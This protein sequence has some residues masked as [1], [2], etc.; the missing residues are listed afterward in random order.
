MKMAPKAERQFGNRVAARG[1]GPPPR[2]VSRP[3]GHVDLG[4]ER[5]THHGADRY[6]RIPPGQPLLWI[7]ERDFVELSRPLTGSGGWIVGSKGR[8]LAIGAALLTILLLIDTLSCISS[9]PK[10]A[11]LISKDGWERIDGFISIPFPISPTEVPLQVLQ[12]PA[13]MRWFS[14]TN[15]AELSTA[16]IVLPDYIAIPYI[17]FPGEV[18]GNRLFLRCEADGH[19]MTVASLRSPPDWATAFLHT[20]GFCSGPARLIATVVDPRFPAR[21]NTDKP[22]SLFDA[23]FIGVA[24]PFAVSGAIYRANTHFGPRALVVF[25]TW[26]VFVVIGSC[27]GI[28]AMRMAVDPLAGA[29]VGAGIV[30]ML[31][32]AGFTPSRET[33]L[34]MIGAVMGASALGLLLIAWR[35]RQRLRALA[36]QCAPAVMLWLG[37]ALA[38]TGFVSV[39]DSGAGSWAVNGL[40]TPLRWSTDNQLPMLLTEA[41]FNYSPRANITWG[42]WLATDRTPLLA[43]LLALPRALAVPFGRLFGSS[44][45]ATAYMTAGITI[46]ASWAAIVPWF[47][48]E[49]GIRGLTVIVILCVASPFLLF[50]TVYTWPKMLGASYIVIAYL[51]LTRVRA[52]T[53][54]RASL[55]FV[56]LCGCL[57][58]L[59][60]PRQ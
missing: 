45:L 12:S 24:T 5:N 49:F 35:D 26:S 21:A 19:E 50:N 42:A 40:F 18:A 29:F 57:A 22:T 9:R 55:V 43:G 2:R 39:A 36:D 6:P 59:S 56:A 53:D 48:R 37:V 60:R 16:P 34:T 58:R 14:S 8:W 1:C 15:I 7:P 17:G 44:F 31:L 13:L 32:I 11:P 54:G 41:L 51:L 30:G 47:S 10:F 46:L 20:A 33:G 38:Y 3:K 52:A 23:F 25:L 4:A 27:F 28:L